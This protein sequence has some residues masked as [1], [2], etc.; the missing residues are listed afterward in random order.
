M[1]DGQQTITRLLIGA[2]AVE[3]LL[4]LWLAA[5]GREAFLEL[6]STPDTSSYL[7]VAQQLADTHTLAASSRTLGYP[8]FAA[9]GYVIGGETYG[10][11]IV[12]GAQLLLNLFL[13]WL[14]WRVLERLAS[15]ASV[16][17]RIAATVFLFW[18]GMGMAALLMSDFLAGLC[19]AVFLY[20]FLFWRQRRGALLA[21]CAL[22]LATLTR[23]TFILVPVLLP[24]A[25]YIV[26]QVTTKI[27]AA[28]L[29]VF[30]ACCVAA[31]SLSLD[32]QYKFN[33]Y[34][35][36]SPI[37][38]YPIQEMLYHGIAAQRS[39]SQDYAVFQREFA[40]EIAKRG[41]QPFGRMSVADR[42]A[43]AKQLL[44]EG[45]VAHP[46]SITVVV[47][48]NAFKYVFAP[49]E[50]VISRVANELLSP[51]T[52]R[53]FVRPVIVAACVPIFLLSLLPPMGHFRGQRP[54]YALVMLFLLYIIGLSAIS[55][56][57]GER[58]RFPILAFM[59]PVAVWNARTFCDAVQARFSVPRLSTAAD[60]TND[61][62]S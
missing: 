3:L 21:A 62:A 26:R 32:Y 14:G 2:A 36:P 10:P 13:T 44:R 24:A 4:F 8:L 53:R 7:G 18:A 15:E 5:N 46:F 33:R 56:G 28:H 29:L 41:G 31:T 60:P 6:V 16:R 51:A 61:R 17:L 59:A 20:G 54:Y 30:A 19:F 11:Y 38:I 12:I 42:E 22:A 58:I 23:P 50:L 27:P 47:V 49:V 9:V 40:T 52:Y 1:R 45:F 25:A 43:Y 55:Y 57:S 34:V 39:T 37:L 35:G 48:T